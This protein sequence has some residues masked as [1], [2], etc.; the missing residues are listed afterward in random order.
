MSRSL[1]ASSV[2]V[3]CLGGGRGPGSGPRRGPGVVPTLRGSGPR[4]K[5][6]GAGGALAGAPSGNQSPRRHHG[7]STS[8]ADVAGPAVPGPPRLTAI[9]VT[10]RRRGGP[11]ARSARSAARRGRARGWPRSGHAT[12]PGAAQP[13]AP[14]P[15]GSRTRPPSRT[16]R[17]RRGPVRREDLGA[18]RAGTR[19][20]RSA[21]RLTRT[22]MTR[23]W[24][25]PRAR[26]RH[27][28]AGASLELI[29]HL[30]RAHR[31]RRV[32]ASARAPWVGRRQP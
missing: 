20:D 1:A 25:G 11:G 27:P 14:R 2:P 12:G 17:P 15:R 21:P 24:R 22:S 32:R 30:Q 31:R 13:R 9:E 29:E 16:S 10:W 18:A 8:A 19:S 28:V 26:V 23:P 5:I 3:A 7:I 4:R 6:R